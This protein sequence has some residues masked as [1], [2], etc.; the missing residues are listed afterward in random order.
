MELAGKIEVINLNVGN[1]KY[2]KSECVIVTDEKYPQSILVEFGG[3][4]SDLL[5]PYKVGENVEISINIGGRKWTNVEGV[6][7]YFNSI[8]GW[9]IKGNSE[10]NVNASTETFVP[11][12]TKLEEKVDDLPF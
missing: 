8:K 6:D 4:K 1:E 3:E 11:T 12:E 10:T 5:D 9:K 2:A 7:K